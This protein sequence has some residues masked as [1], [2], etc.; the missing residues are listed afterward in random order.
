MEHS[1]TKTIVL[2]NITCVYCGVPLDATIDTK[3]HVIGRKFVPS[4]KLDGEWNL[5]VHGCESCNRKKAELEDDISA[6][7][8]QPDAWGRHAVA[9]PRLTAEAHRKGSGS[10][11]R[12]TGKLVKYS[13]EQLSV[14]VPL[15]PGAQATLGLTSPPQPDDDRVF[16]LSLFHSLGFFYLITY[17]EM[18][19]RGGF[20]PG[21]FFPICI[22]PRS[23]WG[24]PI[25]R[26]FMGTVSEWESRVFGVG[27]GEFFKVSMR[28]HPAETCW[29]WAY[30]WNQ[31][32]RIV[33]FFGEQGP[34]QAIV[35]TL[36][37]IKWTTIPQGR[38]EV[39]RYRE[40]IPL[41]VDDDNLFL[42]P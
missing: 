26:S 15:C 16:K 35:D 13:S 23:D 1:S 37:A 8:M 30:E 9:D 3:E 4:G 27:A 24:N 41:L 29:S 34:A 36:P 5:I 7:T 33:G 11:S 40:E 17:N 12:R 28:R 10:K 22:A 31:S 19:R 42:A 38:N 2:D 25:L 39:L 20:W 18:T 32:L 6:I 21:Q 14:N